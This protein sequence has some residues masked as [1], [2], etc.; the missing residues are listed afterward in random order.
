MLESRRIK[1]L[2]RRVQRIIALKAAR[3]YR[4]AI[5]TV[6]AGVPP[7]ELLGQTHAETY[8]RVRLM[9]EEGVR[10]MDGVRAALKRQTRHSL[11]IRWQ[12]YLSEP[13]TREQRVVAA[14]LPLLPEWLDRDGAP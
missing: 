2:M 14:I 11:V 9:R 10:I 6:F 7:I 4:T 1:V 13:G 5:A 12:R 8:R 3:A